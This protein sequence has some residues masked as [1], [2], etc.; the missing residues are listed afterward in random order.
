MDEEYLKEL[1]ALG[2]S[3]EEIQLLASTPEQAEEEVVAEPTNPYDGLG[4]TEEEM[5]LINKPEPTAEQPIVED[6]VR[7]DAEGETYVLPE[8]FE[9]F[10]DSAIPDFFLDLFRA[11]TE[12]GWAQNRLSSATVRLIASGYDSDKVSQ[13]VQAALKVEGSEQSTEMRDFTNGVQKC[14]AEGGGAGWCTMKGI[15]KNPS[16]TTQIMISSLVSMFT[17]EGLATAAAAGGAGVLASGPLGVAIGPAAAVGTLSAFT[18]ASLSFTELL[19]E[20]LDGAAFNDENVA[21]ILADPEKVRRINARSLARGGVIGVVDAITLGAS[22]G[23]RRTTSGLAKAAK[24]AEKA[25]TIA[26]SEF[27]YKGAKGYVREKSGSAVVGKGAGI[28]TEGVGGSIG[29]FGAQVAAGQDIDTGEIL[30]EGF[31]EFGGLGTARV[32]IDSRKI[33]AERQAQIDDPTLGTYKIGENIVPKADIYALTDEE[34]AD[35][36]VTVTNDIAVQQDIQNR[37]AMVTTDRDIETDITGEPRKEFLELQLE[38]NGLKN[39]EGVSVAEQKSALTARMKEIRNKALGLETEADK[40]T[41]DGKPKSK[42]PKP[43]VSQAVKDAVEGYYARRTE[44][45]KRFKAPTPKEEKGDVNDI[46]KGLGGETP[47]NTTKTAQTYKDVFEQQQASPFADKETK[48]SSV[49]EKGQVIGPDG[50]VNKNQATLY[51]KDGQPINQ[52]GTPTEPEYDQKVADKLVGEIKSLKKAGNTAEY[53]SKLKEFKELT[54]AGFYS[55]KNKYAERYKSYT[56]NKRNTRLVPKVQETTKGG[57]GQTSSG[58]AELG[59]IQLPTYTFQKIGRALGLGIITLDEAK[60]ES[61]RA[62]DLLRILYSDVITFVTTPDSIY[63]AFETWSLEER[64]DLLKS[65]IKVKMSIGSLTEAGADTLSKRSDISESLVILMRNDAGFRVES[66]LGGKEIV[67]VNEKEYGNNPEVYFHELGHSFWS[68]LTENKGEK[69]AEDFKSKFIKLFNDNLN[70][71]NPHAYVN[72]EEQR[73]LSDYSDHPPGYNMDDERFAGLIGAWNI[74]QGGQILENPL[75]AD[76]IEDF[77]VSVY[78]Q[79]AK[80]DA[81][82]NKESFKTKQIERDTTERPSYI[83]DSRENSWSQTKFQLVDLMDTLDFDEYWVGWFATKSGG[84]PTAVYNMAKSRGLEMRQD[85]KNRALFHIFT[86][87]GPG[88]FQGKQDYNLF[89]GTKPNI[90]PEDLYTPDITDVTE[91]ENKETAAQDKQF[92]EMVADWD[93]WK[94]RN[95]NVKQKGS[96]KPF[97][98]PNALTSEEV[99]ARVG[100]GLS[101]LE[102]TNEDGTERGTFL[103][104]QVISAI[105]KVLTPVHKRDADGNK[106]E[107]KELKK[108]VATTAAMAW[109]A[110]RPLRDAGIVDLKIGWTKKK[111]AHTDFVILDHKKFNDFILGSQNIPGKSVVPEYHKPQF[112][113]IQELSSGDV[114]YENGLEI[115]SRSYK[116][117]DK[118]PDNIIDALNKLNQT[119]HTVNTKA[120]S[121]LLNYK[122]RGAYKVEEG[123]DSDEIAAAN[124]KRRAISISL[125]IAKEIGNREFYMF[126]KIDYRGREYPAISGFNPQGNKPSKSLFVLPKVTLGKQGWKTMLVQATDS[127]GAK[128]DRLEDRYD[129][130]QENMSEWMKWATAPT[131][132]M[133]EIM[134]TDEPELFLSTILEISEAIANPEG[135][136][137][138]ESGLPIHH[139]ATNSGAQIL[140]GLSWDKI[141]GEI[142]NLTNNH[143]RGDLYKKVAD[144]VW[145]GLAPKTAENLDILEEYNALIAKNDKMLADAELIEGEAGKEAVSE[146]YD[147]IKKW[148][149]DNKKNIEIAADMFFQKKYPQSQMRAIAKHPVMTKYYN[150]KPFGMTDELFKKFKRDFPGLNKSYASVLAHKLSKGVEAIAYEPQRVV[151]AVT[152]AGY[153]NAKENKETTYTSPSGLKVVLAPKKGDFVRVDLPYFGDNKSILKNEKHKHETDGE[154]VKISVRFTQIDKDTIDKDKVKSGTVPNVVQSFDAALVHYSVEHANFPVMMVHDSFSA[155]AGNMAELD[156]I[157]RQG[158]YDMFESGTRLQDIL[159]EMVGEEKGKEIFDRWFPN[160]LGELDI[161]ESLNNP[162]LIGAGNGGTT[163]TDI[164]ASTPES[165]FASVEAAKET[166]RKWNEKRKKQQTDNDAKACVI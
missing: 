140:S 105:Q 112:E 89:A 57:T 54:G 164:S 49:N 106:L 27:L 142:V 80:G 116:G 11:A 78:A 102:V 66:T 43:K 137:Q 159:N 121:V 93:V 73:I 72:D 126:H 129:F 5:A 107:G 79:I 99:M 87:G 23:L 90:T 9:R 138:F 127:F 95:K 18:D 119:P 31:A 161:K 8:G 61:K 38:L 65:V 74:P 39:Q 17:P 160:G 47:S 37:I 146:A 52:D 19:K 101:N 128:I 133:K 152:E 42:P 76:N 64:A 108:A 150:A 10:E 135:V 63:D 149:T 109:G 110:T 71:N 12:T 2:L 13:F 36:N 134:S 130:A 34:I 46:T 154:Y 32:L 162:N 24:R 50:K 114:Q 4:L 139:D 55:K 84:T 132:H 7:R 3:D 113:K 153:H 40:T 86:P 148:N 94:E 92:N 29:E 115:I 136:E 163:K 69:Y 21:A 104:Q 45:K 44:N 28:L 22:S 59:K 35:G 14:K 120:L 20:E 48:G 41:A 145:S 26:P 53:K 131:K 62:K 151:E 155:A 81:F 111:K 16:I 82:G 68:H 165:R 103:V 30:L 124:A 143:K 100:L 117:A 141:I 156:Q 77:I 123:L 51:D 97:F 118:A 67:Y 98:G 166:V 147:Y 85:S 15:A 33:A 56:G 1:Q 88:Q 91:Q 58:S 96:L 125:D 144:H 75:E 60:E 6:G 83:V 122:H 25:G 157:V 158:F 70:S